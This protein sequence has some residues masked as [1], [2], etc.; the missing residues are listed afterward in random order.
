MN[1]V[2]SDEGALCCKKKK[3]KK[4]G[5]ERK[6]HTATLDSPLPVERNIPKTLRHLLESRPKL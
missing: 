5:K 6:K 2:V 4:R 1:R 3:R